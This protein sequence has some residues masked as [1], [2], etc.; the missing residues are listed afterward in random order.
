MTPWTRIVRLERNSAVDNAIIALFAV[1]IAA[2]A[3]ANGDRLTAYGY[4]A[5][6]ALFAL[7][8]I[9]TVFSYREARKMAVL[10]AEWETKRDVLEKTMDKNMAQL[11]HA[12]KGKRLDS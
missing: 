9:S 4:A 2:Q 5:T 12:M 8:S 10:A 1:V 6:S 7:L 3:F 11:E